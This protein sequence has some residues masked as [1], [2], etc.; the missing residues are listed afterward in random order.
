MG[1]GEAVVG[2]IGGFAEG[3]GAGAGGGV[4]LGAIGGASRST[5]SISCPRGGAGFGAGGRAG[6]DPGPAGGAGTGGVAGRGAG[7]GVPEGVAGAEPG[8]PPSRASRSVTC[9]RSRPISTSATAALRWSSTTRVFSSARS[10]GLASGVREGAEAQP[11]IPRKPRSRRPGDLRFMTPP[12]VLSISESRGSNGYR[13]SRRAADRK[14]SGILPRCR[15]PSR[16][17]PCSRAPC[18]CSDTPGT[19]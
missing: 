16:R 8:R 18:P 13:G 1:A 19:L 11:V 9:C 4:A 5:S 14:P 7:A 2:A 12:S 3:R 10:S 17:P 15:S 6:V